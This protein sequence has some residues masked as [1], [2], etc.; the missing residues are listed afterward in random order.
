M[1]QLCSVLLERIVLLYDTEPF[2]TD[3]RKIMADQLLLIF[4][5]YPHLVVDHR[6]DLLDYLGN[7]RTLSVGGEH[8]YMHL[9]RVVFFEG[10]E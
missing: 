6:R 4:E 2:G 5:R 10:W 3:C 1:V 8:C 9:V 7:L